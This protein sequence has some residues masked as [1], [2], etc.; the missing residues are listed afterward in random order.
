MFSC[1]ATGM[2]VKRR[3]YEGVAVPTA[4]YEDEKWSMGVAEKKRLNVMEMRCQKSTSGIT[5]MD[6]VRNEEVQR[7]TGVTRELADRAEQCVLRWFG[8][9]ER[10]EE[11]RLVKRFLGSDVRLSGRLRTG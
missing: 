11:E 1:R 6:R 10:M 9:M 7:R 5:C 4:L 2:N 3:L 8:H